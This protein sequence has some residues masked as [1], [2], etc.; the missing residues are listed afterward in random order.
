MQYGTC[1]TQ[2]IGSQLL[3][4]I[5]YALSML[6]SLRTFR[7]QKPFSQ[8]KSNWCVWILKV[9]FFCPPSPFLAVLMQLHFNENLT[10][11][12]LKPS[13]IIKHFPQKWQKRI[14]ANRQFLVLL[15]KSQTKVNWLCEN[16][17]KQSW[18]PPP[19][20]AQ[21]TQLS[22]FNSNANKTFLTWH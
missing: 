21:N 16:Y 13:C 8:Q 15:S 14:T 6:S 5:L 18:M 22:S 3:V 7:F 20:N 4:P 11:W 17:R 10:L 9:S 12:F 1:P 19:Q 2:T